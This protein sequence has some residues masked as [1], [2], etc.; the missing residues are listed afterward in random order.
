LTPE[1]I[2]WIAKVQH[3]CPYQRLICNLRRYSSRTL[4]HAG[5]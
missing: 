3:D 5:T 2:F 1:K 4:L